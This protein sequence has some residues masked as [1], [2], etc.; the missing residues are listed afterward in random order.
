MPH[1]YDASTKYL[2]EKRLADWLPLCG[3]TTAAEIQVINADLAT[4]T[5]AAD[6]VLRICEDPPWLAH[7]ELQAS[8][9]PDLL[10]N[11]PVYNVVLGR[12]HG[13]RVRT[14]AVLLRRSADSPELT[15]TFQQVF[16]DEP[17]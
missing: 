1:R 2:V 15:G 7:I 11:L 12:R 16:P 17:P 5:A 3:R 9:D 4:V 14:Y 6:R 13:A 8:R 10:P